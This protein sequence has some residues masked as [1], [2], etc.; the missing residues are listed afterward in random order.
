MTIYFRNLENITVLGKEGDLIKRK[1][2]YAL[3]NN[4]QE[5]RDGWI[6]IYNQDGVVTDQSVPDMLINLSDIVAV[7]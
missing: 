6:A 4:L 7:R 5:M 3:D 2:A 1:I